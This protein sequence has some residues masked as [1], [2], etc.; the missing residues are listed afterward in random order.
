[1]FN[2]MGPDE[3]D[4]Q[5]ALWLWREE[6]RLARNPDCRDP[7]HPGCKYCADQDEDTE[8]QL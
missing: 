4:V 7:A 1:M 8:E 2:V 3:D 5:E 6:R